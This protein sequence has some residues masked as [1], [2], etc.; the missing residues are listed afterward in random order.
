MTRS[1]YKSGPGEV[2]VKGLGGHRDLVN[3]DAGGIP[4]GV[5]NG[6]GRRNVRRFSQGF[7]AVSAGGLPGLDEGTTQVGDVHAGG[8]LVV[9]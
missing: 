1:L 9:E 3:L 8:H 4:D 2:P 5:A 7:V 6:R